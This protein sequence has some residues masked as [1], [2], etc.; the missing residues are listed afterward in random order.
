MNNPV[1]QLGSIGLI[2]DTPGY[3]LGGPA[4]TGGSNFRSEAEALASANGYALFTAVNDGIQNATYHMDGIQDLTGNLFY[5][6]FCCADKV[7]AYDGT[8]LTDLTPVA[9][10]TS[11]V[12]WSTDV[13]NGNF[14]FSNGKD[15]PFYWDLN[16][17]NN[18][19]A[20]AGWNIN[21][22]NC[23]RAFQGYAIAL[24]ITK[25]GNHY[26]YRL[27]WSSQANTGLPTSWDETDPA[28]RAGE[29]D[30]GDGDMHLVDGRP[31]G[32]AFI[33]Y[34]RNRTISMRLVGGTKVWSFN[35]IFPTIGA[36]AQNCVAPFQTYHFVVAVGD[37]IYHDGSTWRSAIDKKN[38]KFLFSS[39]DSTYYYNTFCVCY[40]KLDE[41]WVC[42]PSQGNQY[43][44]KAM[45]WN[46][47]L[48]TWSPRDLPSTTTHAMKAIPQ[49][50]SPLK[51]SDLTTVKWSDM[52]VTWDNQNYNPSVYNLLTCNID[53][54][55]YEMDK[56]LMNNGVARTAM[57]ERTGIRLGEKASDIMRLKYLYP[58]MSGSPVSFE[59]GFSDGPEKP[60]T[61]V[62]P[63]TYDP[64]SD[65][66]VDCNVSGFY[67]GIRMYSQDSWRISSIEFEAI[68]DGR[69]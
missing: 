24:D 27:K 15:A 17:A 16:T 38:R 48:D 33:V 25:G 53:G 3:S 9:P 7:F 68:L 13:L 30:L 66:F 59:I 8:N 65:N 56:T 62:G 39:I 49:V 29:I 40:P 43:P 28:S 32:D 63:Y 26:P 23:L 55:I 47:D 20:L 64:A 50:G 21:S 46:Y 22:A 51:W 35:T 2:L 14:I 52:N 41:I 44:N 10:L 67:H 60:Y 42:Y 58:R 6:V 45:V 37:C 12:T 11:S 34:S 69:T 54:N 61:W 36:L 4:I 19:V 1:E 31:L 57:I 18:L 5:E